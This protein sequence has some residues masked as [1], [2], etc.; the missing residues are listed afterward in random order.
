MAKPASIEAFT[1]MSFSHKADVDLSAPVSKKVDV[2]QKSASNSPMAKASIA[3]VENSES[4]SESKK[5]STAD[6]SSS[7]DSESNDDK[8]KQDSLF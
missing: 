7:K 3:S 1:P 8:D 5:T 6:D 4:P 2:E